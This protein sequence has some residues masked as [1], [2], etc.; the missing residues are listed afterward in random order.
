M[1]IPTLPPELWREIVSLA[2]YT[3]TCFNTS[4]R[5]DT[6]KPVTDDLIERYG[7]NLQTK[8]ALAFVS[9]QFYQMTL[10]FLCDIIILCS[11]DYDPEAGITCRKLGRVASL[12]PYL[13]TTEHLL[14][15]S[16]NVGDF[17]DVALQLV[18]I[19]RQCH[20]LRGLHLT[21]PKLR[22][23]ADTRTAQLDV[24][25][26]SMHMRIA[27]AVSPGL[28][29]LS[30]SWGMW[31]N[32]YA[33]LLNQVSRTLRSHRLSAYVRNSHLDAVGRT[34]AHYPD[35]I[36][37][38][39]FKYFHLPL[40][41][42]T[43]LAFSKFNMCALTH[44][45]IG[46]PTPRNA[47][48]QI[49]ESARDSILTL[50]FDG[51]C[52]VDD[53]VLSIALRASHLQL[54]AY[55]IRRPVEPQ[56]VVWLTD[57]LRHDQLREISLG[58]ALHPSPFGTADSDEIVRDH[59]HP[60]SKRKFPMLKTVTVAPLV[61]YGPHDVLAVYDLEDGRRLE[62]EDTITVTPIKLYF[63]GPNC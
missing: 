29:F 45:V 39:Q 14:V 16:I 53:D 1:P 34:I 18:Q 6:W 11:L 44:L 10:E 40:W 21:F 8:R 33:T 63:H 28:R 24:H 23:D 57:G 31:E 49:L 3:P 54:L 55:W 56:S 50:R 52:T 62:D 58:Y 17:D 27:K 60:I 43:T 2:T 19:L 61:G 42:D 36:I 41:R 48:T 15:E 25:E 20:S 7:Y 37:L 22:V 51:R 35:G 4:E 59:F 13:P 12:M 30:I 47:L 5:P 46:I 32:A 9:K 26:L 38:P